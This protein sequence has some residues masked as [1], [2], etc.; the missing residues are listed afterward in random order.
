MR[1]LLVNKFIF[2]KGGAETYTFDVG[3]MLEEHGH[4]VQ[5]FGLENEKNTVGNRI[6][7]YVTNMDFS[8]GIKANLNAPFRIIYSREARKK[9]RAVLDDFQPDVVHL[10]NIQY[11]L[12]PSIILETNKWRKETKKECKIVYTTHDYQL[13]CPSHGMFDVDMKPCE[14]CLDGHYIHCLQTKCLKNSRAKSLLGTLDGYMW[15]YSKAY[16][17]VDAYICC[18]Y[19]LKSKL[20]TQKRFRDKTIGLHNFKKEMPHLDNIQKKGYVLE[21][22]HLSRDKGTDTLL[23]VAKKMP[24]TEFVFIGYGPSVDKMYFWVRLLLGLKW[25]V[26]PN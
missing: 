23:E 22:G 1:I 3:K 17:Y 12:S 26:S 16:S 5:Y 8:Q 18:S 10:N 9:I 7:S 2:P 19:F 13:V 6:G 20:D 14:R 21:F 4:E 25:E 11:H 15:K 24:N